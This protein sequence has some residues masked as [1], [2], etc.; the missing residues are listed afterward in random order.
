MVDRR[1]DAPDVPEAS[2]FL[3]A[4]P[5]DTPEEAAP[6]EDGG[7][8]PA[9]TAPEPSAV[10]V[11]AAVETERD[12]YKEAAQRV[13]ADFENYRKRA[14]A[15]QSEHVDRATGR[16]VS[17][18]LP[19]LDACELAFQHG[20]EGVEPI[21]SKLIGELQR[22]GLEAM[23]LAGQLFDPEVAEAVVHEP[24]DH[25]HPIVSEVLRTGYKWHG[26]VLRP[27]MVKVKG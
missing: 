18:L 2:E 14:L 20:A 24:G 8:P 3:D 12:Q 19:V 16:L 26:R 13:Q 17:V 7:T 23:D 15:Q 25:D 1:D 5:L 27:A 9:P 11:L 4:P 22:E 10:D 21:W 6:A